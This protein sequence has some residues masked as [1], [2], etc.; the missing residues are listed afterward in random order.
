DEAFIV[1]LKIWYDRGRIQKGLEQL[2]EYIGIQGEGKGYLVTFG[3][4]QMEDAEPEW[5]QV[6]GKDIFSVIV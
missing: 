3:L 4:G 6:E 2:A 5:I 1:E